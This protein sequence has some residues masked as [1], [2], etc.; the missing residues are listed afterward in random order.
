MA[1]HTKEFEVDGVKYKTTHLPATTANKLLIKLSKVLTPGLMALASANQDGEVTL[2]LI[3][4][5]LTQMLSVTDENEVD[6]NIKTLLSTTQMIDGS[7]AIR[8]I[9]FDTD[10]AGRLGHMYKVLKEVLD[11]Q[12]SDFFAE[13]VGFV[14]AAPTISDSLETPT[15]KIKAMS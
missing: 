1:R 2:D 9:Q 7:G 15:S 10:F 3:G 6:E 8:P 13:I 4:N 14:G 12:Y 11:F 5:L